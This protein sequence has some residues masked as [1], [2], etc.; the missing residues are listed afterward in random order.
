MVS[1]EL[2]VCLRERRLVLGGNGWK[3]SALLLLSQTLHWHCS[4]TPPMMTSRHIWRLLFHQAFRP[5]PCCLLGPCSFE[6]FCAWISQRSST[7]QTYIRVRINFVRARVERT[8]VSNDVSQSFP[9]DLN[10]I[11]FLGDLCFN[12]SVEK[13]EQSKNSQSYSFRCTSYY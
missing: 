10:E 3:T 13:E 6:K 8:C 4:S 9:Q 5:L 2:L 12:R 1:V 7:R 11:D